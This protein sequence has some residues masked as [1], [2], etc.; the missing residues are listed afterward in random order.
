MIFTDDA[1]ERI[2]RLIPAHMVEGLVLYV[3]HGITPGDFLLAVLR[4]DLVEAAAHADEINKHLLFEY[5]DVMWNYLPSTCW[6]SPALVRA[7]IEARRT[8]T[9]TPL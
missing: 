3:E 2:A 5:A 1:K 7:W 8:G 6:G 4:N 9:E